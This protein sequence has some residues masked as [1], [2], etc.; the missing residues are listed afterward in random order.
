M[1]DGQ[2]GMTV[3]RGRTIHSD[4][5]VN[6]ISTHTQT[7]SSTYTSAPCSYVGLYQHISP[8]EPFLHMRERT[9]AN[10]LHR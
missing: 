1:S 7:H 2:P 5:R 6:V 3:K 9:A 8:S 10:E 4:L